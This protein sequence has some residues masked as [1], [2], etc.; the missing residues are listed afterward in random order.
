MTDQP[1]SGGTPASELPADQTAVL[2]QITTADSPITAT[3]L[4]A[5]LGMT[6]PATTTA[7]A[8][9]ETAGHITRAPAAGPGRRAIR[10]T[11]T[12]AAAPNDT[13][14]PT[15]DTPDDTNQH[16]QAAAPETPEPHVPEPETPATVS[17]QPEAPGALSDPDPTTGPAP[18]AAPPVPDVDT[19]PQP[20]AAPG[21]D[22]PRDPGADTPPTSE[23][24]PPAAPAT[25][26]DAPAE[27][28]TPPPSEAPDAP[29]SPDSPDASAV[30]ACLAMSCPAARCPMRA[31]PAAP[32]APRPR[33]PRPAA[34][35]PQ[36]NSNGTARMRPG[37]LAELVLDHLRANPDADFSAG[38]I[39]KD[40]NRS[41]GAISNALATFANHGVVIRVSDTPRRYKAAAP[42]TS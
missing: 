33:A 16:P 13:P 3:D 11:T 8:A 20:D 19:I 39:S 25:S 32:R 29:D 15:P 23:T 40:I 26:N 18:V 14:D 6:R 7:L 10:W 28:D 21:E 12:P 35:E 17:P 36:P 34:G 30:P 2:H 9:L 4:A 31:T 5:R 41:S 37:Q 38:E 24:P 22:S 42:A 1:T 27:A